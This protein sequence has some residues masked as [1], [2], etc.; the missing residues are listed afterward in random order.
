MSSYYD[1]QMRELHCKGCDERQLMGTRQIFN[2]E[3]Y[4]EQVERFAA[5]HSQCAKF[6][7]PTKARAELRFARLTELLDGPKKR[8]ARTRRVHC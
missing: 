4:V 3:K 5:E 7:N 6:N 1:R 8:P 2:P